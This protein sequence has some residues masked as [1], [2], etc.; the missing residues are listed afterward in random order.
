MSNE[1]STV[2]KLAGDAKAVLGCGLRTLAIWTGT[3]VLIAVMIG[4]GVWISGRS[5]G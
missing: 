4:V 2:G 3:A 5:S 1:D